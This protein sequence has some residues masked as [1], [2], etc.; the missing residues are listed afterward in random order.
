MRS[1]FAARRAATSRAGPPA[2]RRRLETRG[3]HTEP[4]P[5]GA[6]ARPR[7]GRRPRPMRASRTGWS[8]A[9]AVRR[10]EDGRTVPAP[11]LDDAVDRRRAQV[12]PVRQDDRLPPPP[13][14]RANGGRSEARLRGRPPNLRSAPCAR[15]SRP[16][17]P[18]ERPRRRRSSRPPRP[19]R[20]R[21]GEEDPLLRRAEPAR[22]AAASTTAAIMGRY[23]VAGRSSN[24]RD[25]QDVGQ[26]NE[27][28]G[29]SP[30][31]QR[32]ALL[33]LGQILARDPSP[34][35]E[36]LADAGD[37]LVVAVAR[38]RCSMRGRERPRCRAGASRGAGS[39]W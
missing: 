18:R 9:A 31:G 33:G 27:A 2:R 13:L 38:R 10:R 23:G 3:R 39:P 5:A 1:L 15:R 6:P 37:L 29:H 24:G 26:V 16:R 28:E 35:F 4:A 22:L 30:R 17:A 20:A 34:S 32:L 12:G 11:G 7:R 36:E 19:V 25:R 21:R 14:R 8:A